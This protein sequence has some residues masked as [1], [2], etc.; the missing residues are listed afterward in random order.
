MT[1][2]AG[3]V[4]PSS[5]GFP[6]KRSL[7]VE[8]VNPN[9]VIGP[10]GRTGTWTTVYDEGIEVRLDGWRY[11]TFFRY[12][13]RFAGADPSKVEHFQSLCGET[14]GG[15]Y[16]Q[17]AGGGGGG[18]REA[19]SAWGCF[20]GRQTERA[21]PLSSSEYGSDAVR[22]RGS[23]TSGQ[24][25]LSPRFAG[26]DS[27]P[28]GLLRGSRTGT[29][30]GAVNPVFVE[31]AALAGS[32][33]SSSVAIAGLASEAAAEA[34]A[35]ALNADSRRLWRADVPAAHLLGMP[36][37]EARARLGHSTTG[38]SA[39]AAGVG[40]AATGA[41]PKLAT[42]DPVTVD[43]AGFPESLDWST[44]EGGRY[45]TPVVDQRSCG[46]CYAMAT[47]DAL[48][49]RARIRGK[50][51]PGLE[52]V[53]L[54]PQSVV[55][56]S[57]YNQ[58]CDGGYPFLVG[59]F[60]ADI[61]FVPSECMAYT[62]SNGNCP[63]NVDCP[64][65]KELLP[66][67]ERMRAAAAAARSRGTTAA[68][69]LLEV[70]SSVTMAG[71][72]REGAGAG[73]DAWAGAAAEVAA[74]VVEGALARTAAM[75]ASADAAVVAAAAAAAGSDSTAQEAA[76]LLARLQSG[77]TQGGEHAAAAASGSGPLPFSLAAGL[78]HA[79]PAERNVLLEED[80]DFET[81]PLHAR[82]DTPAAG[83][84]RDA[85]GTVV[86]AAAAAVA[87]S[88]R[89]AA[90][91]PRFVDSHAEMV[92]ALQRAAAFAT[93][94]EAAAAG[95][96]DAAVGADGADGG[97]A[98]AAA[99]NTYATMPRLRTSRYDYVGG[100]YGACTESAMIRELQD[101]PIPVAFNAAGDLFYYKGGVYHH[102]AKPEVRLLPVLL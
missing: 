79:L 96:A 77:G 26:V 88:A 74:G 41:A 27:M 57:S 20:V 67:W 78:H 61:G 75:Q 101:G 45:V 98:D 90:R 68:A 4:S 55:Q 76:A 56:C 16:H 82:L 102:D 72:R 31:L 1:S 59:M 84:Q 18:G 48:S 23:L 94:E 24:A 5:P 14:V 19:A 70:A 80:A 37:T 47:A 40:A 83:S 6:V 44:V 49:S 54:S 8:L 17:A 73:V 36:L 21:V 3:R 65:M 29:G 71:T 52:R 63:G 92:A 100:Y 87:A 97:G 38:K 58:G 60:G 99:V 42:H 64:Q 53:T 10:E 66:A 34:V 46:S 81:G 50:G 39:A 33:V 86:E 13:P 28:P 11:F 15:W 35:A 69:T 95:V 2:V 30:G 32:T 7:A 51:V 9:I 91:E 43:V 12:M 89:S 85:V 93:D 62:S 22:K 25:V